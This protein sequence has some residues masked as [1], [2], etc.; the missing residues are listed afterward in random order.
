MEHRRPVSLSGHR[1][2]SLKRTRSSSCS[3]PTSDRSQLRQRHPPRP[4]TLVVWLR[5]DKTSTSPL[6]RQ[7]RLSP[8]RRKPRSRRSRQES[9][10]WVSGIGPRPVSAR[11]QACQTQPTNR[12]RHPRSKPALRRRPTFGQ[13]GSSDSLERPC[14]VRVPIRRRFPVDRPRLDRPTSPPSLDIS[15]QVCPSRLPRLDLR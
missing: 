12:P 10:A 1:A 5:E 11:L 15:E 2:R 6:Q 4:S 3:S 8:R 13:S 9:S 7:K 14:F